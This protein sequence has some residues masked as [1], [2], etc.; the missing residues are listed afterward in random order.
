MNTYLCV[1]RENVYAPVYIKITI[2]V[3]IAISIHHYFVYQTHKQF[4]NFKA[5]WSK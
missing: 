5:I 2:Q 4:K 3:I 1:Y